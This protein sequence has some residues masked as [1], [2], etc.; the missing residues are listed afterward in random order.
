[1][2]RDQWIREFRTRAA[3]WHALAGLYCV[4]VLTMVGSYWAMT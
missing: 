2:D 1:M 3:T 4:I